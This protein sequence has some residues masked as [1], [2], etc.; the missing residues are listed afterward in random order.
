MVL[1]SHCASKK[2]YIYIIFLLFFFLG[3]HPWQMEILQLGVESELQPTTYA[4]AT[5]PWDPSWIWDL[6]H[7]SWQ[8]WILNPLGG[9]RDQTQ[10]LM[11]TSWV[12]PAEPHWELPDLFFLIWVILKALSLKA[13]VLAW[14]WAIFWPWSSFEEA[15]AWIR[16]LS[17]VHLDLF[18]FCFA[19]IS[20]FNFFHWRIRKTWH[21]FL[22]H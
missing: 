20:A 5:A 13:S 7:S 8:C 12:Q 21:L 1:K 10:I 4:T 17:K 6:Y 16:S 3:L 11:D 22:Q 2:K 18:V 15:A 19:L 14:R 9:A